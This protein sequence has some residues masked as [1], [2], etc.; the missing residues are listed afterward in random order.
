LPVISCSPRILVGLALLAALL[1]AACAAA[2]PEPTGA[3][4]DWQ[5][6]TADGGRISFYETLEKGPALL[7][8]WALWCRPCL[9]ELPHLDALAQEHA[10]KLTVLAIN[11]DGP[12]SVAK[13]RPFL[14]T[15]KYSFQVPLDTAGEIAR[16]LQ[17][18]GVIP[19][20]VL[21][22]REGR[23]VYR[24]VGYKEGDEVALQEA[25]ADLLAA[26]E[27]VSP[28]ASGQMTPAAGDSAP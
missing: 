26:S 24:H 9:K 15:R 21:F 6:P 7:S 11:T 10:G 20:V 25:V 5:L 22:D 2:G 3:V 28:P 16:L 8:F 14:H 23:E 17:I 13:V 27:E 18:G 12:R 4:P 1:P 19:F